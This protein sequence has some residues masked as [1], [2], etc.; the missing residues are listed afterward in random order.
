MEAAYVVCATILAVMF[1]GCV[2]V[3]YCKRIDKDMF[4]VLHY[5]HISSDK[6]KEEV[7]DAQ[8]TEVL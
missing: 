4:D 3:L 2:T 6:V 8:P 5:K 1:M 7:K